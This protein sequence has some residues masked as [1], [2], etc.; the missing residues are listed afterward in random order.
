[1]P[2]HYRL[3]FN[4][5]AYSLLATVALHSAEPEPAK[6]SPA[7]TPAK[8]PAT[9][10]F[11]KGDD[12]SGRPAG[13]P[14]LSA[15]FVQE[16]Y[17]LKKEDALAV[18]ED[19]FSGAGR[20]QRVL[21][22]ERDNK[23]RLLTLTAL[24]NR[25]GQKSTIQGIELIRYPTAFSPPTDFMPKGS[26][27]PTSFEIRSAG[28]TWE[29]EASFPQGDG[30]GV[31]NFSSQ[32]V[33][34]LGYTACPTWPGDPVVEQPRFA[35]QSL[36]A[37]SVLRLD[38]PMFLGTFTPSNPDGFLKGDGAEE[39]SLAFLRVHVLP[40]E[41]AGRPPSASTVKPAIPQSLSV[42]YSVYSL[43]RR[44]ARDVVNAGPG[45]E[46]PWEKLQGFVQ[47]K[48]AR[49][50]HVVAVTTQSGQ[51]S[52]GQETDEVIYG[53]QYVPPEYYH[54]ASPAASAPTRDEKQTATSPVLPGTRIA[55]TT[56][57]TEMNRV[58][59]TFELDPVLSPDG[60]AV[61]LVHQLSAVTYRG[62]LETNVLPAQP[63]FEYRKFAAGL[64]VGTGKHVLAATLNPPSPDGVNGRN[65][66]DGR[67]TLVF[68]RATPVP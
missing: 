3:L 45:V 32:H 41:T 56:T 50:E 55:G 60:T 26:V 39:I 62:N 54:P 11:V 19:T 28:D 33:G 12:P 29:M 46:G 65:K 36:S 64:T 59:L 53:T 38:E 4:G 47:E 17:A 34:L 35:E 9:D 20:Y 42:L 44:L 43:D 68:V 22:L 66:D 8:A 31:I 14:P 63:L 5:L 57:V 15:V 37:T 2:P 27:L 48:R 51:K 67:T 61:N 21:A 25:S 10:P 40:L 52:G 58:G 23:A 24:A 6:A 13:S 7:S 1:M 16:I 18:L 30:V 49:I